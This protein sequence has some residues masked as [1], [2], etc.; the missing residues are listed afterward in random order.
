MFRKG[1]EV[2]HVHC[3]FSLSETW[4]LGDQGARGLLKSLVFGV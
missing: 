2:H 3:P 1:S 4:V